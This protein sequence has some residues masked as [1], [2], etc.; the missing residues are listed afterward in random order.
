MGV[1]LFDLNNRLFCPECRDSSLLC[2]Q[3]VLQASKQLKD[4]HKEKLIN[5]NLEFVHF[6][7]LER[8]VYLENEHKKVSTEKEPEC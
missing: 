8:E 1:V 6:K 4:P 2:K 7:F 3:F 5:K